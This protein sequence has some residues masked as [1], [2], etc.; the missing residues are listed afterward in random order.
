VQ[1]QIYRLN[2]GGGF[3]LGAHG[4]GTESVRATIPSDTLF[5]AL[6]SAWIRLGGKAE[7]W[8]SAFPCTSSDGHTAADP[9]FLLT[10]AFP[11]AKGTLFFPR[12]LSLELPDHLSDHRKDWKRVMFISEPLFW[13]VIHGGDPSTL[14]PQDCTSRN[15]QLIQNGLVLVSPNAVGQIPEQIWQ[16]GKVLDRTNLTSNLYTVGRVTFAP[17]SGLWF[18]VTWRAP[19]RDCGGLAFSNAFKQAL[20]ELSISGLGGDRNMGQGAFNYEILDEISL[21]DNL[22]EHQAIVL[23]RYHPTA[24]ELPSVLHSAASY[25]LETNSGWGESPKGQF[26]RRKVRFLAEGSVLSVSGNTPLGDLIDLSPRSPDGEP[27]IGHPV[28]RYGLAFLVGL[29]GTR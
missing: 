17:E 11:Y 13:K 23:S 8:A 4:I 26:R 24:S 21:P 28:W 18:G 22:S 12:P 3:H 2:F 29:G 20:E 6:L 16:E 25:K 1:V 19:S 7:N 5:S 15:N 10:S 14:W 27:L 9:P